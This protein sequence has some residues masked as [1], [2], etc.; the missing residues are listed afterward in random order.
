MNLV[1]DPALPIYTQIV[2]G[3]KREICSGTLKPGEKVLPVRELALNLGVN[4][5]TLQRALSELEREGLL[6]TER[7]AGRF[8]TKDQ[9]L[10]NR[11]RN[12]LTKELVKDFLE[13]MASLGCS[14]EEIERFIK[15]NG[16]ELDNE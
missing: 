11:L 12:D 6:Y 10:I 14:L 2:D 3:F 8:I 15:E 7:T 4:P 5:N 16:G 13:K 9:D 1:F